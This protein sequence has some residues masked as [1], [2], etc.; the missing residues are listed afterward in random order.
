MT[1]STMELGAKVCIWDVL[2]PTTLLSR[3]SCLS[4]CLGVAVVRL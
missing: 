1:L 2:S 4:P 3:G